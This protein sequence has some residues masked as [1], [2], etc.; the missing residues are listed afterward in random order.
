MDAISEEMSK[1]KN[2]LEELEKIKK[3]KDEHIN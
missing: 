1:L 2:K 3:E